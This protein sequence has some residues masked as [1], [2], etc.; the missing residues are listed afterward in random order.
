[1]PYVPECGDIVCLEFD[2]ASGREMK[3]SH[4]ALV[5]TPKPFTHKSE[6]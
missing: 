3:N 1:M 2:P 4:H 6:I 5:V